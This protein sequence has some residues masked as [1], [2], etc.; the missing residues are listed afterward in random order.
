MTFEEIYQDLS[1]KLTPKRFTHSIG[2]TDMAET[3]AKRYGADPTQARLAGLL[4]DCAKELSL[5]EMYRWLQVANEVVDSQM[6]KDGALL[7]GVVGAIVAN[8]VY[9][10]TDTEILE[11]IRVHTTGK[12]GMSILDK[13]IF[14]ADYIEVN[15]DFDGVDRLRELAK[16]DLDQAVLGG[17][18]NTI[19]FLIK[20]KKEI[21]STTILG[22][23]DIIFRLHH[24]HV[25]EGAF[26]E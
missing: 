1:R 3:L 10:V 9:H 26:Y 13:I 5:A 4:H 16:T 24:C 11:A 18:D 15:R 17:Y 6:M 14:V 8:Y 7:H 2:V 21:Y 19:S 23:N 22:R 12:V 25:S 20:Q